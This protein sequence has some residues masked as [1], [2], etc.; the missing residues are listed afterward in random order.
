MERFCGS[1]KRA[2]R[3]KRYPWANLSKRT[4]YVAMLNQ[5]WYR[6]NLKEELALPNQNYRQ[7][8]PGEFTQNEQEFEDCKFSLFAFR[9][10]SSCS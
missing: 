4:Y 6:Y 9:Y 3:S 7:R 2:L 8:K 10:D 5:L 1:L